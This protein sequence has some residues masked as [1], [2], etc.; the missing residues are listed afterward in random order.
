MLSDLSFFSFFFSSD[1]P[2]LS[3][4]SVL[5]LSL[6][7]SL[8]LSKHATGVRLDSAWSQ[9]HGVGVVVEIDEVVRGRARLWRDQSFSHGSDG[10][11]LVF[12]VR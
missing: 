8:S 2:F 6:S 12:V 5:T 9:T 3:T 7:L 4:S 10:V 11:F 1:S